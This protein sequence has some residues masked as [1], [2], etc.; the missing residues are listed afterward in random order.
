MGGFLQSLVFGYGG[1]R[2]DLD[3]LHFRLPTPAPGT[4]SMHFRNLNY[5]DVEFDYLV[6]RDSATINVTATGKH[7]LRLITTSPPESFQLEAGIWLT[8]DHKLQ[9]I[10]VMTDNVW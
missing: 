4:D 2:L 5:L 8:I 9:F 1:F 6:D 10:V 7:Q 3:A